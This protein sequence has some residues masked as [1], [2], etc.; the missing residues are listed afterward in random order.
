MNNLIA[1]CLILVLASSCGWLGEA[2]EQGHQQCLDDK[3]S[4]MDYCEP[5]TI[6]DEKARCQNECLRKYDVCMG[7]DRLTDPDWQ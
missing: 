2:V 6:E 7:T 1:G 4:C 3:A 5:W